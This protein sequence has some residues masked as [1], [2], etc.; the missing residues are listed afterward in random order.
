MEPSRVRFL[1]PPPAWYR[2]AAS[3]PQA[4]PT[5]PPPSRRVGGLRTGNLAAAELGVEGFAEGVAE[6][7]EAEDAQA[8]GDAGKDGDPGRLLRVGQG[9]ARQHQS[10]RRRRLRRAQAE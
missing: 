4:A 1:R 5:P 10:P 6:E 3:A 7:V 2:G 9:R 8:D